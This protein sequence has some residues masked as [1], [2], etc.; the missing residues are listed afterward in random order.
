MELLLNKNEFL[1]GYCEEYK[2][3][4]DI[5]NFEL[6]NKKYKPLSREEELA[7]FESLVV[8]E[9]VGNKV[10]S[11]TIYGDQILAYNNVIT[12]EMRKMPQNI[13]FEELTEVL[14]QLKPIQRPSLI[15]KLFNKKEELTV[16]NINKIRSLIDS[17][18]ETLRN[19]IGAYDYFKEYI[20][21][22]LSKI[23]EVY[24]NYH[25]YGNRIEAEVQLLNPND[26]MS[27]AKI[28]DYNT[29]LDVARSRERSLEVSIQVNNQELLKICNIIK[30]HNNTINAL[31]MAKNDI[32]PLIASE[33]T[34]N[35][36]IHSERESMMLS[37]N[38]VGLFQSLVDN[39]IEDT[40]KNLDLL[41]T[42]SL[43][44]D[45][46]DKVNMDVCTYIE[47]IENKD[48]GNSRRLK[49]ND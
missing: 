8:P 40:K 13:S 20:T 38:L 10:S 45:T 4:Y 14:K 35:R 25:E 24:K 43:P 26:I 9:L 36:G 49:Q 11:L 34:I 37:Q 15:A 6:V 22:Y 21:I 3:N 23:F 42:S 5:L 27:Y 12:D 17:Y 47:Q 30:S 29:K 41:Q 7:R 28:L 19:E 16:D 33:A 18:V 46:L 39:N 44:Q 32:L 48:N 31:T 1:L 2:V